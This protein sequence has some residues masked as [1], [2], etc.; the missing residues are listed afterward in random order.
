MI[1]DDDDETSRSRFA[2][3][4]MKNTDRRAN[5]HD[6]L[7]V[8]LDQVTFHCI[9]NNDGRLSLSGLV[10]FNVDEVSFNFYTL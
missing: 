9:V 3:Y 7:F 2:L 5:G 10:L 1:D 6:E 4:S 8:N